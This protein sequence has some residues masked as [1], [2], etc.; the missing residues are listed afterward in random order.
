METEAGGPKEGGPGASA[1][2]HTEGSWAVRQA[3]SKAFPDQ[4]RGGTMVAALT[5]IM[6]F[7]PYG[8]H[9]RKVIIIT[10]VLQMSKLRREVPSCH[11]QSAGFDPKWAR[12]SWTPLH[13]Q[14]GLPTDLGSAGLGLSAPS[15]LAAEPWGREGGGSGGPYLLPEPGARH[16]IAHVAFLD[17][18]LFACFPLAFLRKV[19]LY[20]M[21]MF[22]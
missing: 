5:P 1:V 9:M 13:G 19:T 20:L 8:C 15:L 4:F 22:F 10:P 3:A 17:L 18:F 12:G 11:G 14:E 2:L 6:S 16:P 21:Q 7:K